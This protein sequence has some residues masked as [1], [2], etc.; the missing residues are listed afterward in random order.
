MAPG[1]TLLVHLK[2]EE[3]LRN[4]PRT[5]REQGHEVVFQETDPGGIT[6]LLLRRG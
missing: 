2:G 3:P 4:V 1:Q 5:A 6:H